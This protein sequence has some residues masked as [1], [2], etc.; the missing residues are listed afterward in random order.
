MV[1]KGY[2]QM[3]KREKVVLTADEVQAQKEFVS[4]VYD[5]NDAQYK[6][7]GTIKKAFEEATQI[8]KEN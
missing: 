3:S 8:D 7:G 2:V 4:L 6:N 1:L 5:I